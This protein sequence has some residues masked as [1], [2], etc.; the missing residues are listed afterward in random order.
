[1]RE[2]GGLGRIGSRFA[3]VGGRIVAIS[4]EEPDEQRLFLPRVPEG[5]DLVADPQ[6][7]IVDLYGLR[8][9]TMGREVA[10]PALVLVGPDG[11]IARVRATSDWK[12]RPDPEDVWADALEVL[13]R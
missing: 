13:G 6:L 10:R 12:V 2:L 4:A 11:R 1:M 7:A 8:H 9:L 5:M 3:E